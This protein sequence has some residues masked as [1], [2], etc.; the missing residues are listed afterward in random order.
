MFISIQPAKIDKL[1]ILYEIE[2]KCFGEDVFPEDYLAYLLSVP[3]SISL[4]ARVNEEI[5]GFI[6]GL[7]YNHE[8][9]IIGH[10]YTLDVS[11]EYRR[12]SV[13]SRLLNELERIFAEK[14]IHT[15]Y[16][17]T[18][19]DDT[20]A[21]SFYRKHGYAEAEMLKDY[22]AKG[23]HGIRLRKELS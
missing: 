3:N 12:R 22:Y 20:V 19:L 5:A 17:E 18:H 13:G 2:D 14:G 21:R 1:K 15:C 23:K 6:I 10:V 9:K 8:R 11:P 4:I 7:F 16:L